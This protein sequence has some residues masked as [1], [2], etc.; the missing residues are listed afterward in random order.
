MLSVVVPTYQEAD[1]IVPLCEALLAVLHTADEILVVD[2]ASMDG[3]AERARV[4]FLTEA[5]V[6]VMTRAATDRGLASA[7]RAGI[8]AARGDLVAVM[9]ADFNHEPRRVPALL[10][11][12]AGAD[13]VVGSR[14]VHGGG[15]DDALRQA[16]SAG[17]SRVTGALLG[18]GTAE[19]LSGFFVARAALLKA[20][21]ADR[22]YYGY[23]DYFFRLLFHAASRGARIVEVPVWYAR[24]R[25]GQSKTRFAR[26]AVRYSFEVA[27]LLLSD[28]RARQQR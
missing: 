21:P 11:Q 15:M 12:L 7:V 18:T 2:D 26:V 20:L 8:D 19:N 1:N 14:F 28:G 10:E 25:A 13:L 3:T 17:F 5:R 27:R 16:C 9:D 22:I 24:R 23:G 6:R 4:R